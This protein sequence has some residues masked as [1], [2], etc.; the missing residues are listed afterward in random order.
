MIKDYKAVLRKRTILMAQF[1]YNCQKLS[2]ISLSS[3]GAR[4]KKKNVTTS[5]EKHKV[6]IPIDCIILLVQ[7]KSSIYQNLGS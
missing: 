2:Q 6:T 3:R 7:V 5:E 4:F 1:T